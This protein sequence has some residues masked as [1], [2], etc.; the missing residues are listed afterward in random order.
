METDLTLRRK[1]TFRVGDKQLVLIKKRYEKSTHVL[2]KA[3]LWALYLPRYPNLIVEIP[4]SDR[5][6]PDVVALNAEGSAIFWGEA[7]SVGT[8]K[9]RSL[10]RRYRSTHFAMAKWESP[11][12]PLLEIVTD[13]LN[14]VKR[15]AP[16]DLL[17]FQ[18]DSVDLFI[19]ESGRINISHDYLDWVSL[20]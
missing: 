1:W 4:L 2:M 10:L 13:A 19:D 20:Y 18:G 15:A 12:D 16:V 5:Y 11:L 8:R 7:G 17:S 14:G 6:K 3:F 9:I